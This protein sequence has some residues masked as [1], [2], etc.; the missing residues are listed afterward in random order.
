MAGRLLSY[1]EFSARAKEVARS[2]PA[3]FLEGVEDV[4]VHRESK[5]HPLLPEVLTLGECEPSPL[6]AMTGA[7][8]HRSIVHLY[9]GSFAQMA[10]LD[11]G[12]DL[13]GELRETIEHEVQ[14]HIEDR[15][16]VSGLIDEDD[17]FD[18]HERFRA[19]LEVPRGWY[20][21]GE[22]L[23]PDVYAV[24]LDLFVELRLRRPELERLRGTTLSLTILGEPLEV[25]LPEDVEAG[26]TL[27]VE[28][29]GL[30]A[31][32]DEESESE[33]EEEAGDLHLIPLLR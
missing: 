6:V 21:R 31:G 27:T 24:E 15:A 2:I 1:E 13:E 20:R 23:E 16:G 29:Q 12:F 9:Y 25:D 11:D 33:G 17:L 3:H 5:S 4:V 8:P 14:H 26:E 10:R 32:D 22:E 7:G 19:G 30:V 18:A 28:G